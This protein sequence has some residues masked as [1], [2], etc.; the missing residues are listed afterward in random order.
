MRV[1]KVSKAKQTEMKTTKWKNKDSLVIKSYNIS[2]HLNENTIQDQTRHKEMSERN[3]Y[4]C[5]Q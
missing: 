2:I 3:K 5:K 4:D 1:F